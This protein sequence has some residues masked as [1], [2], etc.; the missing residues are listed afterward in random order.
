[1]QVPQPHGVTWFARKRLATHMHEA[2]MAREPREDD[3][4]IPGFYH[5]HHTRIGEYNWVIA[6]LTS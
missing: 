3:S 5:G 6:W 4:R 1:M 2:K